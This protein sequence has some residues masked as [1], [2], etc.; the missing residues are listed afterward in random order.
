MSLNATLIKSS[1]VKL[2]RIFFGLMRIGTF[3]ISQRG[4]LNDKLTADSDTF[5]TVPSLAPLSTV[6]TLGWERGV[7]SLKGIEVLKLDVT[8]HNPAVTYSDVLNSLLKSNVLSDGEKSRVRQANARAEGM[9]KFSNVIKFRLF[10]LIR[11]ERLALPDMKEGVVS[12]EEQANNLASHNKSSEEMFERERIEICDTI[13]YDNLLGGRATF[14]GRQNE[15][16]LATIVSTRVL[17]FDEASDFDNFRF[18]VAG[19]TVEDL[20]R[21]TF[22]PAELVAVGINIIC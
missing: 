18:H 10:N 11:A 19:N 2:S 4:R 12:V 1:P 13:A 22:T 16:K 8:V 5:L 3:S 14:A 17:S 15:L 6:S 7:F 9:M 20:P 21:I